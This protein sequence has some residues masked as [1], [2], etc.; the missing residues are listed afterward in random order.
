MSKFETAQY[1]FL[2]PRTMMTRSQ[3]C[4]TTT[5]ENGTAYEK[6]PEHNIYA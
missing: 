1:D 4:V 5:E 3:V 6:L 2:K